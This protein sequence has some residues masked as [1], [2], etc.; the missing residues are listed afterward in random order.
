VPDAEDVG[1]ELSF[2][3]FHTFFAFFSGEEPDFDFVDLEAEEDPLCLIPP[4]SPL[5]GLE[6]FPG[7][8]LA[9]AD[10]SLGLRRLQ[11]KIGSNL[12]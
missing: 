8:H 5:F 6:P 1:V 10:A 11:A 12:P 7:D 3:P 9:A 4:D 2:A